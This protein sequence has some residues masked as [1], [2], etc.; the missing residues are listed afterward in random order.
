MK[1]RLYLKTAL[2]IGILFVLTLLS[3]EFHLR[4][5]LT[6]E[7]QYTLSDAT[8]DVLKDLEDPITVKAYFSVNLPP[9]IIKTRQDFQEM[10]IEYSNR[11][12][13]LLQYEFINPNEKES[14]EK[15]AVQ[16]GIRPVMI[17]IREKDQM[18]QPQSFLGATLSQVHNREF[19]PFI[20]LRTVIEYA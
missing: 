9:N 7:K 8:I 11:A 13:G 1:Q 3:N 4:L 5:D 18:K 17:N 16:N 20:K 19:N 6:S 2:L 12:G 10:L 14:T 15:E